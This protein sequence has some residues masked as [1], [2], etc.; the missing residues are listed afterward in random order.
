MDDNRL[1]NISKDDKPNIP[2]L[3]KLELVQRYRTFS[4]VQEKKEEGREEENEKVN[5]LHFD[6]N[7]FFKKIFIY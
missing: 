2:R 3:P 7:L 5:I 4:C 6:L 1:A